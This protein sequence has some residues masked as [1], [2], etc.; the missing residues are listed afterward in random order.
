MFNRA[1]SRAKSVFGA[2]REETP[3]VKAAEKALGSRLV[4]AKNVMRLRIQRGYT[5]KQ[6]AEELGVRQ[7]R[8]AEIEGARANLQID[9]L[10]R[11]AKVFGVEAATLLKSDK[12]NRL[13]R[14]MAAPTS[15]PTVRTTTSEDWGSRGVEFVV[16]DLSLGAGSFTTSPNGNV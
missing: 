16:A 12:P 10:D 6:L 7:P 4:V 5:Q 13:S 9:T 14:V 2:I 15:L 8:I 11:L 3:S 1:S